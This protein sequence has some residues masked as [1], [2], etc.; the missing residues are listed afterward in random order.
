MELCGDEPWF[1]EA[2]VRRRLRES[3]AEA[4]KEQK[5]L[6]AA[7]ADEVDRISPEDGRVL[8]AGAVLRLGGAHLGGYGESDVAYA[9]RQLSRALHPDKNP[10]LSRAPIAFHRLSEAADELRQGLEQQRA[11]LQMLVGTMGGQATPQMLERPQEALFAEATRMLLAV[12]GVVGEGDANVGGGAVGR[13]MA[14]F[15]RSGIYYTCQ[16]QSLLAEWFEKTQLLELYASFPMRTAY[17]CAPKRC[18]AQ[19]LCLLNRAAIVEAKRFNDCVRGSWPAIMQTFPELGLWRDLREHIRSRVWDSAGEPEP[20]PRQKKSRSR[21]RSRSRRKR[22]R[23]R[24]RSEGRRRRRADEDEAKDRQ[25]RDRMRDIEFAANRQKD[26]AW[27][28]RWTTSDDPGHNFQQD[29]GKEKVRSIDRRQAIET[30]LKTGHRACRWGRK[31]RSA[32]T[33]I[34]PSGNESAA[35]LNDTEVRKL[36]SLLW[37]DICKWAQG[38]ECERVLGLFKADHQTAKTFGW[39]LKGADQ[40][41]PRGMEPGTPPADWSFVP[42]SDLL[43]VVGEGLVGITSEGLYADNPSGHKRL[44]LEQCFKKPGA[45]RKKE[46]RRERE[47]R[48]EKEKREKER[49]RDREREKPEDSGPPPTPAPP[50]NMARHTAQLEKFIKDNELSESVTERLRAASAAVQE[51][52][53]EQGFNVKE[54]ARNADAVVIS[55]VRKH[56]D[57]LEGARSRSPC[58]GERGEVLFKEGDWRCASCGAHN[59]ARRMEC[60]KCNTPRKP[61]DKNGHQAGSG[62]GGVSDPSKASKWDVQ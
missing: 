41:A 51:K 56:Q 55:R 50:R 15:A 11:A 24:S 61:D 26:I 9:Y 1:A 27:D 3:V 8:G 19:F 37:K 2:A 34:L 4:H 57:A 45:E 10:D 30:N 36:G 7:P 13:A 39:D 62:R 38:S 29:Q 22:S 48:E 44:S 28:G 5:I 12:C 23:S 35:P 52:V 49:E 33:A 53:M 16:I 20:P 14:A 25:Q 6:V 43:L 60:F 40:S 47:R 58:R 31:W 54:S 32:I 18:R 42:V 21:K 46:E 17:D 59:F